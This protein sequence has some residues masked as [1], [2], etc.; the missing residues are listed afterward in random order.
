MRNGAATGH[1]YS[2][3]EAFDGTWHHVAWVD[4]DGILDLYIDGVFDKQFD[5]SVIGAFTPDTTTIGGILRGSDCC[6]FTGN[7]DD[8]AI[9]DEAL[10]EDDIAALEAKTPSASS[11]TNSSY[12]FGDEHHMHEDTTP[13]ESGEAAAAV[14]LDGTR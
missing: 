11:A 3:G 14:A 4:N 8:L 1:Q 12:V 5:H 9:W 6:N 10:S 13:E 7:I 2:N